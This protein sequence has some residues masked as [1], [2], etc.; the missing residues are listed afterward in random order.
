M[1]MS[2]NKIDYLLED[3]VIPS[4]RYALITIIG[5]HMPQKCDVWGFKIRGVCGTLEE[6]KA[7][8]SRIQGYDNNYDI[9][10]V[11]VGKFAPLVVNP[12]DIKDVVY[13]NEKLNELNKEYLLQN[14]KANDTWLKNK[15][16]MIAKAIEQSKSEVKSSPVVIYTAM[17]TIK[18]RQEQLVKEIQESTKK[19]EEY[20]K[21][22]EGFSAE[23]Q[24]EAI[25]HFNKEIFTNLN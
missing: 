23:E 21:E 24:D 2:E 22:F 20:A 15:N 13:T 16:D 1:V 7:L 17:N 19:Y 11:E 3:Q 25:N 10:T 5:P 8:A 12:G 4:Q 9:H 18:T 14:Q 6:S